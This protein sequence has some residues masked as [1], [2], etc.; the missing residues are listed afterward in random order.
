MKIKYK[1]E[2]ALKMGPLEAQEHE[3]AIR[4]REGTRFH[5]GNYI[6]VG[7]SAPDTKPLPCRR[8]KTKNRSAQRVDMLLLS[9]LFFFFV[10]QRFKFVFFVMLQIVAGFTLHSNVVAWGGGIPTRMEVSIRNQSRIALSC[11]CVSDGPICGAS[12]CFCWICCACK[13]VAGVPQISLMLLDL[14]ASFEILTDPFRFSYV[15]EMFKDLSTCARILTIFL[16]F[17]L[18]SQ[19]L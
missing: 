7:I 14:C 5:I 13:D 19:N 11:S 16:D 12:W 6:C 15:W 2:P 18:R 10:S 3:K 9:L 17:K 4:L 8:T 1:H